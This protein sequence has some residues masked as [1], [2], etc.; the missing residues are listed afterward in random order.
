MKRKFWGYLSLAI[1]L[2]QPVL[3][4][5]AQVM[6]EE[7]ETIP[8]NK[9]ITTLGTLEKVEETTETV[10]SSPIEEIN[11]DTTSNSESKEVVN[12]DEKSGSTE[13][14]EKPLPDPSKDTASSATESSAE[15]KEAFSNR[16]V[17]LD[18]WM[19][20]NN[21]QNEVARGLNKTVDTITQEDMVNLKQLDFSSL[22]KDTVVD[23]TGLEYASNLQALYT[24][25][26]IATNVPKITMAEN[27]TLFTRPNVL[28]HILP[29][30]SF[31]NI[32]IG[33]YDAYLTAQELIGVGQYLSGWVTDYL[34]VYASSMTDFSKLELSPEH[35]Q[36][37]QLSI[38]TQEKI[39]LEPMLV[40][41][42]QS[43]VLYKDRM[44]VD[45]QGNALLSSLSNKKYSYSI[46]GIDKN[47]Y[48]FPLYENDG[49]ELTEEGVQ[50][51][52]IPANVDYL[53]IT[54]LVPNRLSTERA[55]STGT[56]Q[57]LVNYQVPVK[58]VNT[59]ED[60]TVKYLDENG[61]T[62]APNVTLSGYV[63]DPF[64]TE[65]KDISGYTLKE[66][67]GDRIGTF[68]DVAQ[69]V[70]YVYE[71]SDAA[72]VT[73]KYE[74]KEGN[75]LATPTV[76]NGKIGLPYESE[77]KTINGWYVSQTPT[78]A[79][80]TYSENAQE[81]IYVYERSD[82]APVTVKY[83]DTE[84]NELA[85]PTVMNGKIGLP[86]ES[87]AKAIPG[88]Y[89][90]QMPTNANGIYSE[91]AQEVVYVYERS[92]AAPVTVKYEDTEGNQLSAPTVLSGKI[93]LPYESE[94]KTIPGWYVSQMP[95]NANGTYSESA[96]EVIYVYERSDAA[97]VT[98]KYEDT[99]GNQLSTSTIL[100][101]KVG[102]PYTSEAKTIPGWFVAQTPSNAN[103]TY[104]ETT[105]EVVYVYERSD[106]APVT[107]KYKDTEGN[108][109]AVS[110]VMNGKIGLPYTSEAKTIPGWYVSQMPT[111][112]NGTYSENAQEVT[113][114]YERSDAAL[115]IV[116]YEDMEGNQLA[117]PT[118]L[119]G[120]VG[121]SFESNA[122]EISG[123]RVSKR[124]KSAKGTF[125]DAVQEV[126][127]VYSADKENEPGEDSGEDTPES[128]NKTPK[129]ENGNSSGNNSK[130][131]NTKTKSKN[132]LPATG[133]QL[134]GQ[135]IM[136]FLG[137]ITVLFSFVVILRRKRKTEN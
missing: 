99:E 51:K 25:S 14:T 124:P 114:V 104:S 78:N 48:I 115:V 9:E 27:A 4:P 21:L 45:T 106:A 10:D 59:A 43:D 116:R 79:N 123:W 67:Q 105:Q 127:Y 80:G 65:E 136:G 101:G 107:V 12:D 1:L 74:D 28:A 35:H 122:K 15:M 134:T 47:G 41:D 86:Y 66:I 110:T 57:Y 119:S 128:E 113:Y 3:A 70:V 53:S 23:F 90:S 38:M 61:Q 6:A 20:D 91:T 68:S 7:Q 102:L 135:R 5:L 133:E 8:S 49:F 11:G 76:M 56:I 55:A 24:T 13:S 32:H 77:A 46:L 89:V 129:E 63:G 40:K 137:I 60:V 54:F 131:T 108:E 97:P 44:M 42:G 109:L 64:T 88:W 94:A 36:N 50:F 17:S 111:N 85:T 84:G 2:S 16:S 26:I 62:L 75:E 18:A 82:A 132:K 72:P 121:L 31:S 19:P 69:E 96:Q 125:S 52:N 100:N 29:K 93:G 92:D 22:V 83:E 30:G 112:A 130:Q 103:G 126:I 98:V 33:N 58:Y 73:V 120:K 39:L 118:I 117:E 37:S 95:E 81:V 71:R 34:T 87:E